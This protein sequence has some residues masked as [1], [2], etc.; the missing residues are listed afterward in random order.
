MATLQDFQNVAAEIETATKNISS[1]VQGTGMS[2]ADQNAAL[3]SMQDAV[4]ALNAVIPA[5]VQ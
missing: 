3:K 4:T 5:P 2:A 1:Y